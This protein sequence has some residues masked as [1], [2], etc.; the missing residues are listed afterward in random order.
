MHHDNRNAHRTFA[1]NRFVRKYC[2]PYCL[3]IPNQNASVL[4]ANCRAA[5]YSALQ[6]V[7]VIV[8]K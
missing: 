8:K 4:Q 3:L 5:V 6:A 7:C 1:R 2:E